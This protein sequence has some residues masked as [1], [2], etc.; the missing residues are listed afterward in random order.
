MTW[1]IYF[2]SSLDLRQLLYWLIS[3]FS[4]VDWRNNCL[5]LLL[6]PFLFWFS[7]CGRVL[8]LLALGETSA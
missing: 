5:M 2:S 1:L 7:R 6:L 8:Y 3:W 4:G